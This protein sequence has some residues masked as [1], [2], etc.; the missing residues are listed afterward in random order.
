MSW[1]PSFP[2]SVPGRVRRGTARRRT[3]IRPPAVNRQTTPYPI[4]SGPSRG[5]CSVFS[6]RSVFVSACRDRFQ[7]PAPN[8]YRGSVAVVP[9]DPRSRRGGVAGGRESTRGLETHRCPHAVPL[10]RCDL[11]RLCLPGQLSP[12]S[13]EGQSSGKSDHPPCLMCERERVANQAQGLPGHRPRTT[14]R[15]RWRNAVRAGIGSMLARPTWL[16]LGVGLTRSLRLRGHELLHVEG[17]ASV[18]H[19][20]GRPAELVREDR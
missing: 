8:T 12:G 5:L 11:E 6:G 15:A 18:E 9:P 2:S 7:E 14:G 1:L 17:G 4:C 16:E 13:G 3:L 10:K 20:V 19:V